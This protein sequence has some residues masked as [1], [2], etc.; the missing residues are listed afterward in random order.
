MLVRY[1]SG[2]LNSCN[3]KIL[4]LIC[5][6]RD[7]AS[8][9]LIILLVANLPALSES[10]FITIFLLSVH[11]H[12]WEIWYLFSAVPSE[13]TQLLTPLEWREITSK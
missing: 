1:S 5:S 13:A 6:C 10:K 8:I 3:C 4:R 7:K 11:L 12:N 2:S 9:S